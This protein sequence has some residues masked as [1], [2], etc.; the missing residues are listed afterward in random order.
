MTNNSFRKAILNINRQLAPAALKYANLNR[1][2]GVKPDAVVV[3]GMG[4]SGQVGDLI[5]NLAR[6]LKIPV[7]VLVWKDYGLPTLYF[8]KLLYILI[9]FSG[10]TEETLSSLKSPGLKTAVCSGGQLKEW[11]IKNKAPLAVFSPD[12][13]APR[14][15]NGYMFYGAM[16]IIRSVFKEVRLPALKLNVEKLEKKGKKIARELKGK[17]ILVYAASQNSYL[18]YNWKTRL[19]ETAKS[20]CFS[21]AIPEISHNEIVPFE[22]RP[23]NLIVVFLEDNQ[24]HPRNKKKVDLIIKLLK[25]RGVK[26]LRLNLRGANRLEK[27][28]NSLVLADWV[29][30][31]LA[32]IKKISPLET[33]LIDQLK[34]LM[35]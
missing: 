35:R 25:N 6:E 1:L 4:G 11:A 2:K 27:T 22:A 10:N 3:V 28:W 7:P 31:H 26:S 21:G 14:Q 19:N 23:K 33:K 9:S 8:K 20:L 18:A 16:N 32:A 15:A 17:M 30:Y 12:R 34:K 13:L 29:G 5:T 24:D